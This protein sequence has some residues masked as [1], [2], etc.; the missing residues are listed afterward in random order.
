M[1]NHALSITN[2]WFRKQGILWLVMGLLSAVLTLLLS[3]STSPL[4]VHDGCD[5]C[6]FQ[7]MGMLLLQGKVPYVDLFD[8]KGPMLYFIQALG[9]WLGGGKIG[10]FILQIL[11]NTISLTFIYKTIRLFVD[12]IPAVIVFAGTMVLYSYF[13]GEGNFVEGWMLGCIA[14]ALYLALRNILSQPDERQLLWSSAFYGFCLAM[15][16]MIR[17]ND[18]VI[19]I[20]GLMFGVFVW[21]LTKRWYKQAWQNALV[22]ALV[23]VACVVPV[24]AF[25]AWHD[26]LDDLWYAL[27]VY[28]TQYAKGDA[29]LLSSAL[30]LPKLIVLIPLLAVAVCIGVRK[31]PAIL[32]VLAVQIVLAWLFLGERM[33]RHY[34]TSMVPLLTL[35]GIAGMY[36][37]KVTAGIAA[38]V[39]VGIIAL[40]IFKTE[41]LT[42]SV[43]YAKAMAHYYVEKQQVAEKLY[44]EAEAIFANVPIEEQDQIWNYNLGWVEKPYFSVF[45]HHGI[46]QCNRVPL[47]E[48]V[49][50]DEQLRRADDV[51]RERPLWIML[52]RDK[53]MCWRLDEWQLQDEE[54]IQANY[55][56]VA[57]TNPQICMIELWKRN[58]E[59]K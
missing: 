8:H 28:N 27:I 36:W 42:S 14:P 18:A 29:S 57:S 12:A 39:V 53:N 32:L 37:K 41:V 45:Y 31:E 20:G 16:F 49:L 26:A 6:V 48:M 13:H 2:K 43:N 25:Y 56:C 7:T 5:S 33:Y 47:Y 52:T 44:D 24:L 46:I 1:E 23:F 15:C 21:M 34:W 17:P 54:F 22:M 55:T 50:V 10:I 11:V 51:K 19:H 3:Y 38:L 59:Q 9:L 30:L 40:A 58:N 35:F 4:Y